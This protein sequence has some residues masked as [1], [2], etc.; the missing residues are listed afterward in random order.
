MRLH[1][2]VPI[3]SVKCKEKDNGNVCF[4]AFKNEM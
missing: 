3:Y 4:V 2:H 1:T